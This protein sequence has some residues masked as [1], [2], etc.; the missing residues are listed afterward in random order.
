MVQNGR[1]EVA[2]NESNHQTHLAHL[3]HTRHCVG[4]WG[5]KDENDFPDFKSPSGSSMSPHTF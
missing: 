2:R 4:N 3:L 5:P 1:S